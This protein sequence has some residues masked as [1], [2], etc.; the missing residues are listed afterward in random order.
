MIRSY[1]G[2]LGYG[3]TLFLVRSCIKALLEGRRV[4]SNTPIK[5]THN[6][7]VYEAEFLPDGKMFQA[8]MIFD[9]KCVFAID[10]AAIVFPA[11]FWNNIPV[12]FLMKFAQ[13][14]KYEC[15]FYYTTQ[16]FTH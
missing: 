6:N 5:F 4:I 1:V 16:G 12:D 15:D 10:E 9:S 11:Y 13:A 8:R 7:K 14:R 2:L 3:K